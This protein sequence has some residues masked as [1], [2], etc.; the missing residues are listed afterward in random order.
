[1]AQRKV[2]GGG[3]LPRGWALGTGWG[4]RLIGCL[5]RGPGTGSAVVYTALGW[6]LQEKVGDSSQKHLYWALTSWGMEGDTG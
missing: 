5:Q 3:L 1:M 2:E 4:C 6:G